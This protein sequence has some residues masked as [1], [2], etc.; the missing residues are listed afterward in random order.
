MQVGAGPLQGGVAVCTAG[1]ATAR[2]T[3]MMADELGSR[4][5]QAER[6][7]RDLCA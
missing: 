6:E 3:M 7:R 4:L 2:V 1:A 5:G